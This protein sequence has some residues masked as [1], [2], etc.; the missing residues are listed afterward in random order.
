M[1][2]SIDGYYCW[3]FQ[4]ERWVVL[5]EY[6]S[7]LGRLFI[8]DHIMREEGK[9]IREVQEERNRRINS[10]DEHKKNKVQ[11]LMLPIKGNKVHF[12]KIM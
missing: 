6:S 1:F 9:C 8:C 4:Q 5:I 7:V 10:I 12:E 3:S 11:A 2:V